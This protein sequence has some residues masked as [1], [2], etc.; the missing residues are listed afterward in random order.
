[1]SMFAIFKNKLSIFVSDLSIFFVLWK[2]Q[3]HSKPLNQGLV[4][5]FTSDLHIREPISF[6]KIDKI[7]KNFLKIF[8]PRGAP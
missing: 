3:I 2:S 7:Q 6:K 1:M 4:F 5:I 8:D